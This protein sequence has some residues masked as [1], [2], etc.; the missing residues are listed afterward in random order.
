[1]FYLLDAYPE[2]Y[3]DY[4]ESDIQTVTWIFTDGDYVNSRD[5]LVMDVIDQYKNHYD[6]MNMTNISYT[7][8]NGE[9]MEYDMK[10]FLTPADRQNMVLFK[11]FPFVSRFNETVKK[12]T[13]NTTVLVGEN[14]LFKIT[15]TNTGNEIL[16]EV[17][18]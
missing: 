12:D 18:I 14:V 1:M 15:V 3:S 5:R 8:P 7:L 6:E 4:T 17:L 2:R 10:L 16:H 11:S 13:I 9:L